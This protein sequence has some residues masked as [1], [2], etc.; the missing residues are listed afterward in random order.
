MTTE[1][2][3]DGVPHTDP[4]AVVTRKVRVKRGTPVIHVTNAR[5]RNAT[6]CGYFQIANPA[7]P[8]NQ[9]GGKMRA[10]VSCFWY[11]KRPKSGRCWMNITLNGPT[12]VIT[13]YDG[14][15]IADI[16]RRR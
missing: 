15:V 11:G 9:F 14:D 4:H 12:A 7:K 3:W 6:V 13:D 16:G 10:E 8:F 1:T 2:D 5:I